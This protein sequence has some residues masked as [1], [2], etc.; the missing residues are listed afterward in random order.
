MAFGP[1]AAATHAIGRARNLL[2]VGGTGALS[3]SVRGDMRRL[4]IVMAVSALD[5]Y[6]HRLVVDRC[7]RHERLP[8]GLSR[9]TIDFNDL[10]GQADETAAAARKEPYKPKPRV[11]VKRTLRD[12]L[13]RETFQSFDEVG[14][15]M[16]MAGRTG[17]PWQA[18]GKRLAPPMS[19]AEVKERLNAI[20]V[21]RNRIVHEGD[22]V[23]MER[24]R[25][26]KRNG[27]SHTQ[28]ERDIDFLSDLIDA[29]HAS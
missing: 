12:R 14:N 9:L 16:A 5:T 21:R 22:Y 29:I 19:P 2:D 8:P 4:S 17:H 25:T 18:V 23:R 1:Y 13:L 6:M 28:A 26:P 27:I 3:T 11:G 15:A 7:Y 10:L 24:P 20:V